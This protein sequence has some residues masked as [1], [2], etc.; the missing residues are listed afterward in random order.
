MVSS[1]ALSYTPLVWDARP[2]A[3]VELA[4]LIEWL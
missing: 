3:V 1:G 4:I 2:Q